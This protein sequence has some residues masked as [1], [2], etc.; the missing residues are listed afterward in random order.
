MLQADPLFL[1]FFAAAFSLAAGLCVFLLLLNRWLIH[2]RDSPYKIQI[3]AF[4]FVVLSV[5]FSFYGYTVGL[6]TGL[7]PPLVIVIAVMTGELARIVIRR[8][9][10]GAPPVR[11]E[12]LQLSL[13][14][15][16]TTTDLRVAHYEVR[17]PEWHGRELLVAHFSDLHVS[18]NLPGSYYETV[19]GRV[20]EAEPDLIFLTGDFVTK[21]E[22]AYRLTELLN[23]LRSRLGI[24]AVLGN[25]DFWAGPSAVADSLTSAGI[26]LLGNGNRRIPLDADETVVVCGCE[27]PWSQT[28]WQPPAT[29][30]GELVLML[31]HTP[32]NIYRLSRTQAAPDRRPASAV[33][34]GHFHA[35][36]IQIP[37]LG[38]IVVPSLYGRRFDH[39]HFI[40]NRTHLFVT[41]GL[42]ADMPPFRI[43][44]QPDVFLVRFSGTTSM[45][46]QHLL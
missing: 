44:C 16:L 33:F 1:R 25:H 42:G 38:P 46:S 3:I 6:S 10:R 26:E 28:V 45:P 30:K 31:T 24:F 17:V 39:G 40:V 34:A 32:D 22:F 15:P 8:R 43:F 13:A 12:N 2:I 27:E 7:V 20:N 21:L 41:A 14:R 37:V 5:S 11:S 29:S 4:G 18:N 35:G 9:H 19:I 36:Q 23:P